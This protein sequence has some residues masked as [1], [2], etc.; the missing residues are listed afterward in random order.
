[1]SDVYTFH[2]GTVPVLV[3][4]PHD[5]RDIPDD[6]A[7]KMTEAAR[8]IPDTDWHV[9][10]L[11]DFAAALGVSVMAARNSRY[12]VD[13]NRH[14]EGA[15]LYPGADNTEVVPTSTFDQQPLYRDEPPNATEI[16]A[17]IERYCARW[18]HSE[19]PSGQE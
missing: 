15:A 9:G 17:R 1:M 10:R 18:G 11:Y 7:R 13:L 12:V 14:P 4:V 3:S 2:Q 5:G 19:R 6:I 16:A 8:A